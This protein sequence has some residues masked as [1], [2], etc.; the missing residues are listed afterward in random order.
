MSAA[1][2]EQMAA[3]IELRGVGKHFG[4]LEV[5]RDIS[6]SVADGEIVALLGASGCGKS[7]LLNIVSGLLGPDQGTLSFDGMPASEFEH[8]HTIAYL[9]QDDRLLPWRTTLDNAAFGLEARVR[10]KAERHERAREMLRLVGLEKFETAYPHQLSGGMRARAALARS[11]AIEP[12]ILLMDEPFSKLDPN[13][14]AQMHEEVLRLRALRDVT[15]LFVTHDVEEAVIL[16]DRVVTLAPHPGRIS[17][18]VAMDLPRPRVPTAP[19]VA[20]AVRQLR[21]N[22]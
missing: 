7:T 13:T 6:F 3:A 10:N 1:N 12:A 5:L 15:V 9:F 21:M 2:P 8:W 17:D 22:I 20:E 19:A 18:I 11:L 14:R 4:T 16:A